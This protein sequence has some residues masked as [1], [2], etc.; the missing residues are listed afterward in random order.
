[1]INPNHLETLTIRN[2]E[3]FWNYIHYHAK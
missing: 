2:F 3:Y 1:M